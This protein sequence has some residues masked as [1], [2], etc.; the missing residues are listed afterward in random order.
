[1]RH[2]RSTSIPATQIQ[3]PNAEIPN[4]EIPNPKSQIIISIFCRNP[5]SQIPNTSNLCILASQIPN[6]L[7]FGQHVYRQDRQI[8]V[9]PKFENSPKPFKNMKKENSWRRPFP[10]PNE[11]YTALGKTPVSSVRLRSKR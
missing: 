4:A 7:G 10:L 11:N 5:K 2:P 8:R 6:Y 9:K 3:N 1:M